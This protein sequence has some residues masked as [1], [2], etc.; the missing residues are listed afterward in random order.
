MT[1]VCSIIYKKSPKISKELRMFINK[2]IEEHKGKHGPFTKP[3]KAGKYYVEVKCKNCGVRQLFSESAGFT[4][5][6]GEIM[7]EGSFVLSPA[8]LSIFKYSKCTKM[9]DCPWCGRMLPKKVQCSK[10]YC[11]S[12]AGS[13]IY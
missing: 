11:R 13:D 3:K 10:G 12:C 9:F 1:S 4:M 8:G 5:Y 6:D 2:N 7:P